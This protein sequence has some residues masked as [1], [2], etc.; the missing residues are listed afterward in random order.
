MRSF[1]AVDFG[2]TYTKLNLF[3]LD[4]PCLLAQSK[5]KTSIETS[6]LFGFQEAFQSLQQDYPISLDEIS[7]IKI[8]SSAAGGLE[9]IVIGLVPE[10]TLDAAQKAALGAG[11][12]IIQSFSFFLKEEDIKYLEDIHCDILLLTGGSNGGNEEVVLHNAVKLASSNL[13]CSFLYSGNE[14]IQEKV[15]Q[16]F[17][18]R[19]KTCF[20]SKNI[21]P[22]VNQLSVEDCRE[23]IREIFFQNIIQAKGLEALKKT[24]PC[25]IIPTP[26]AVLQF[27]ENMQD[28]FPS[29]MLVDIGGATTDIHSVCEN[30]FSE[31]KCF[32]EGLEEPFSKRT[33]EGDLGMRYS[34]LSVWE[35]FPKNPDFLEEKEW[36]Q[37]C[38]FRREHPHFIAKEEKEKKIDSHL[39][40][41]CVQTA[42]TRHC[43]SLRE[44]YTVSEKVLFQK[45][46]DFRKLQ[47]LIATGGILVHHE[48]PHE[49]LQAALQQENEKRLLKP[50]QP[51]FLLDS[52]YLAA[53]LGLL[54]ETEPE[55]A[56]ELVK[57]YFRQ[58]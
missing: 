3:D 11:A 35:N 38:L 58:C 23:K 32:L 41:L 6:I 37:S 9:M 30:T 53:S 46:K 24:F 13:S 14:K 34:S 39:A 19:Q 43:G 52:Y 21:M 55:I 47:Y 56:K 1:L 54:S 15:R 8:C 44:G 26:T 4:T 48:N 40:K 17:E 42:I 57:K 29:S 18:E 16:I 50:Q 33:V 10:L 51:V 36:K 12:R 49:I 7:E 5:G 20:F 22:N 45:G 2:S 28:C 25:D 27:L 31:K